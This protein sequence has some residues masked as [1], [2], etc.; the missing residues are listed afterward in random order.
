MMNTRNIDDVHKIFYHF[1]NQILKKLNKKKLNE[2]NEI[3]EK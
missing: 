2:T 1:S 3:D